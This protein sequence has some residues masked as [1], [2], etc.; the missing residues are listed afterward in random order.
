MAFRLRWY[1]KVNLREL[2]YLCELRTTPQAHPNY[3]HL[4]QQMWRLVVGVHPT[5][6]ACGQFV[7]MS[8]PQA[9]TR[10]GSEAAIDRKLSKLKD[11]S[12]S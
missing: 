6:G 12:L 11:A 8:T 10:L 5:L 4:A 3:R 9:L 2:V 1:F 7:D